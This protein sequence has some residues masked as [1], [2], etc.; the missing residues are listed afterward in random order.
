MYAAVAEALDNSASGPSVLEQ[1]TLAA[2][3]EE[4]G[5]DRFLRRQ[6]ETYRRRRDSLAAA[7]TAN[8]QHLPVRGA[9]AGLHLVMPLPQGSD[10]VAVTGALAAR[11]VAASALS[12]YSRTASGAGLVLGYGRL[13]ESRVGWAAEQVRDVVAAL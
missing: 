13:T 4:G 7:L 12:G 9:A 6:R 2:L 3:I 11:G 10:D 5:Y 8:P 1:I